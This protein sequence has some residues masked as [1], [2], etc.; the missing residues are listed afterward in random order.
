M[1]MVD[2]TAD[3]MILGIMEAYMT[4]GITEDGTDI[5]TTTDGI[6]ITIATL[7]A[8]FTSRTS[9]M[10]TEDSPDQKEY[11]QAEFQPEAALEAAQE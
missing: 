5:H 10:E 1:A 6:T 7:Q 9:G 2:G 4:H 11:L 3:G 8:L